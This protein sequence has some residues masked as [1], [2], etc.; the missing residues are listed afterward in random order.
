MLRTGSN[1]R[2][3]TSGSSRPATS[4]IAD[5][6]TSY[7]IEFGAGAA[8]CSLDTVFLDTNFGDSVVGTSYCTAAVNSTGGGARIS[9]FGSATVADN[10][11]G[12]FA[13]GAPSGVSG[14]VFFGPNQMIK[15][16]LLPES[17]SAANALVDLSGGK[18]L[19]RRALLQ[20]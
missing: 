2:A 6:I 17:S 8:H 12:V 7:S 16:V 1:S 13:E 18:V 9:A 11:F 4:G 19:P 15:S 20:H 3:R 10:N 5:T 14:I